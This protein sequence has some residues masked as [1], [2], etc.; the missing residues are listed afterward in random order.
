[1]LPQY[2]RIDLD[3]IMV[4]GKAPAR[5]FCQDSDKALQKCLSIALGKTRTSSLWC[6]HNHGRPTAVGPAATVATSPTHRSCML[7]LLLLPL[8]LLLQLLLWRLLFI[9]ATTGTVVL[10]YSCA[11]PTPMPR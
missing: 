4:N 8:H 9:V 6:N 3:R 7:L 2:P 11:T 1:M 10:L 5:P